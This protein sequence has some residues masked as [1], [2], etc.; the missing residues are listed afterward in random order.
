MTSRTKRLIVL[1]TVH[2]FNVVLTTLTKELDRCA[3]IPG[4]DGLT[5]KERAF[6]EKRVQTL[7]Q[8]GEDLRRFRKHLYNGGRV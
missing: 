1:E 5:D 7:T 3:R 4:R 6:L 8:V 2:P